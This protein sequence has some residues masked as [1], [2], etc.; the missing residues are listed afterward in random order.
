MVFNCDWMLF[1]SINKA[2]LYKLKQLPSPK[3]LFSIRIQWRSHQS[4]SEKR[5]ERICQNFI[6]S[7]GGESRFLVYDCKSDPPP[8]KKWG[9]PLQLSMQHDI[10]IPMIFPIDFQYIPNRFPQSYSQYLPRPF[11]SDFPSP[12]VP[13]AASR[14][15][16]TPTTCGP[17]PRGSARRCG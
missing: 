14:T 10:P 1:K 17:S 15:S 13:S 7:L 3:Q 16:R 6:K 12:P 11:P 4:L 8:K 2:N 9:G 5:N